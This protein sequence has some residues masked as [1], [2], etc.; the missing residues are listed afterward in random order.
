MKAK[1]TSKTKKAAKAK[2]PVKAK[3]PK[4]IL[5]RNGDKVFEVIPAENKLTQEET[6]KLHAELKKIFQ[7]RLN[8]M[9]AAEYVSRMRGHDAF[10]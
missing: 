3:K 4:T 9:T 10:N 1:N 8:G 2:K 7:K 5:V 6:L